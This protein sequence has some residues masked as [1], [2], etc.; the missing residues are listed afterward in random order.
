MYRK[1]LVISLML[2][3]DSLSRWNCTSISWLTAGWGEV[4]TNVKAVLETRR[5]GSSTVAPAA[6]TSRRHKKAIHETFNFRNPS[7]SFIHV[8]RCFFLFSFFSHP[9]CYILYTYIHLFVVLRVYT[10]ALVPNLIP[11]RH[12]VPLPL[13]SCQWATTLNTFRESTVISS[14]SLQW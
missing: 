12:L 5:R 4:H 13:Y 2:I 14:F 9:D 8:L 7:A 1:K 3:Y 6:H 10:H 11:Q